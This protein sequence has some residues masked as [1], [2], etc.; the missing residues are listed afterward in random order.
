MSLSALSPVLPEGREHGPTNDHPQDQDEERDESKYEDPVE[1]ARGSNVIGEHDSTVS[2]CPTVG[3]QEAGIACG[4]LSA[5]FVTHVGFSKGNPVAQGSSL[6]HPHVN[7]PGAGH[8][9]CL[10]N[11][12]VFR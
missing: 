10:P 6:W 1:R 12:W 5:F 2:V 8:A 7:G 11:V 3:G 4:I 9:R